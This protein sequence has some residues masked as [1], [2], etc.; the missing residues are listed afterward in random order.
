MNIEYIKQY[1]VFI[2]RKKCRAVKAWKVS[3]YEMSVFMF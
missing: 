2:A 1:V 3:L